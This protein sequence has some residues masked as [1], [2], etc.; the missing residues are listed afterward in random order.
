MKK[1][2][3]Y[4]R[5]LS[6]ILLIALVSSCGKDF[7]NFNP[8]ST[9]N[10]GNAFN[11][12]QDVN[13]AV[14]GA[15]NVF[16]QEYYEWD[17][18]LLGDER[19]DNAYA[20]GGGDI[21]TTPYDNLTIQPGNMRM[22]FDWA[23]LYMGIA[24]CNIILDKVS[25]VNDPALEINDA[26]KN[27][28]GQ[29]SFLR[30]YHYY[31][32]VKTWGGVPL[33]LHSNSTDPGK[34]NL[35]RS[36]EKEVY[37][38]I[39]KDLE[40]AIANLPDKF[41]ED[42]T[43]NKVRATKG[44]ANALMAKVWA[45]RSDRDYSKVLTY[46]D[47]VINSTAGYS[48]MSNYADL[49]DGGHYMNSESILEIAFRTDPNWV[50]SNWGTALFN[51]VGDGF[52]SYCVPS[53]D[54]VSLYDS[55]NDLIRKNANI[56]FRKNNDY[57]DENWN[58]CNDP[59]IS[60]PYNFKEKHPNGWN[61]GDHLYLLRLADIIL[62]KAEAQNEI[63]DLGGAIATVNNSI[64][65]SRAGLPAISA[66]SKED[67]RTK[68]LDERRMELAFEG[69]RFDDLVRMST[70][71]STMNNLNEYKSICDNGIPG[72]PTKIN[73]DATPG[74]MLCPIPQSEIDRNPNLT[75]NP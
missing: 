10:T 48:L 44:A 24:R 49:F 50:T 42:N 43:E 2:E 47:A 71:V 59:A 33:E 55:Q 32:L 13:N 11:T 4:I 41:S 31:H 74:K 64:I 35:P 56:L 38:Q 61:G 3:L 66:T 17:Y 39:V 22:E 28:I 23:Q 6:F 46:C 65:R 53:K 8:T 5:L 25:Q 16:Y 26:R 40:V 68:I 18:I 70:F 51:E 58:P 52:Q 75:P 14:S 19:S 60:V 63:N 1:I 72:V 20:G 21:S 69:Q 12:A 73:Y 37:D 29:A 45:Q 62:L 7:L 57:A 9:L 15:Y 27:A 30:A 54:L 34:T 67:M 36:S